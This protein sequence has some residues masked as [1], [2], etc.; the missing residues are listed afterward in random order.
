MLGSRS[1]FPRYMLRDTILGPQVAEHV[2]LSAEAKERDRQFVKE[3]MTS[4]GE[5]AGLHLEVGQFGWEGPHY[6]AAVM[7][8][9]DHER[10]MAEQSGYAANEAG[11]ALKLGWGRVFRLPGYSE[12]HLTRQEA[13]EQAFTNFNDFRVA[14]ATISGIV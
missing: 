2:R 9:K 8:E 13:I 11:V 1:A 7:I 12:G 4:L 14:E 10:L 5:I 3:A 6:Y